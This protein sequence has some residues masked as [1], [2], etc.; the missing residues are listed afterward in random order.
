[1]QDGEC[2]ARHKGG[3]CVPRLAIKGRVEVPDLYTGLS[4]AWGMP[5][6]VSS[7]GGRCG[8]ATVWPRDIKALRLHPLGLPRCSARSLVR[9]LGLGARLAKEEHLLWCPHRFF[10]TAPWWSCF[11]PEVQR[12]FAEG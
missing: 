4:L 11:Y 10:S 6:P 9:M 3:H 5:S 2:V 8:S 1:M 7:A 12:A